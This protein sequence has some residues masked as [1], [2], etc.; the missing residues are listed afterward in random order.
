MRYAVLQGAGAHAEDVVQEAFV[1]A[2]L[3][4]DS[5]EA[6]RPFRPWLLRIVARE[7]SN[8]RRGR[9][10]RVDRE[11]RLARLQ[12]R[13]VVGLDP[14]EQVGLSERQERLYAA[15]RR[16]P[17]GFAEVVVCRYLLDLTEA[18]TAATVGIA[19]GTVKS[20]LHRA[21]RLL[22]EDLGDDD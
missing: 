5:F 6:G 14:V 3:G 20:R 4:L 18:E 22:R 16:L 19:P 1:K 17:T 21:L 15:V 10:R 13:S 12:S 11:E 8:E 7:T 9:Q 2:Y